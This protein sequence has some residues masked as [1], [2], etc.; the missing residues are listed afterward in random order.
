M[1]RRTEKR[2]GTQGPVMVEQLL[3][4]LVRGAVLTKALLREFVT[5]R[6]FEAVR[7]IFAEEAAALAGVKRRHRADRTAH[8]WGYANAELTLGGRRVVLPRPRVRSTDGR[9]LSLPSVTR[10]SSRDPLTERVLEQILLGVSTRKY[11]RSLEPVGAPVPTRATSKCAVSRTFVRATRERVEA[12]LGSSIESLDL[13]VLMLDG[14]VVKRQSV[15]V[16]LGVDVHGGKHV[17][18]LRLGST[19]NAVLCTELLQDLL[20][21]GLKVSRPLL[22][23]IDGGG[24]LRRALRDVFGDQALIQRCQVH[25]I[26]NVTEHLSQKT[27][28]WVGSQMREDYRAVGADAARR[29]LKRVVAWLERNGHEDAA[30]SLREGLEETLTVLKLHLPNTL[31][32]SL[33]TTNAIENLM[34]SIRR[35]TRRVSRWKNGSMTRRWV[36]MADFEARLGFRRLKGHREMPL[37]IEVLDRLH[38]SEVAPAENAA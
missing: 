12:E 33:S 7:T 3:L 14:I 15:V 2:V 4:P 6:G 1:P 21:R 31:T 30:G 24:G 36:A 9:E 11:G 20:K 25:K 5:D 34:S 18:G 17:L 38:R 29:Q 16:A 26:R 28:L 8:H 10:F 35:T 27:Q 13:A 32:R 22:C 19:E 23:V 37:L